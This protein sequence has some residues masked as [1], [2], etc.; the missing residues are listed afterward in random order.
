VFNLSQPAEGW[1][2]SKGRVTAILPKIEFDSDTDF[3]LC[4]GKPMID[5]AK[6]IL[7]KKNIPEEQIY[8]EQFHL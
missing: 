4:G 8:F 5:D 6:K 1:E 3:Y 2:G 7:L